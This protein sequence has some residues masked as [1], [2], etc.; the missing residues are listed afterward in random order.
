MCYRLFRCDFAHL[1]ERPFAKWPAARRQ[2]DFLDRVGSREIEALPDRIM[3][4]VNRQESRTMP[5][6][7]LHDEAASTH[8]HLFVR[9]SDNRASPNRSKRGFEPCCSYD[10]GHDPV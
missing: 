3:L 9:E 1:V 6:D 10:P 8:Q 5:D 4:A 2:N 7:F